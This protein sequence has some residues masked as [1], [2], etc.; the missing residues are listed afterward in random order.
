MKAYAVALKAIDDLGFEGFACTFQ[1]GMVSDHWQWYAWNFLFE[2]ELNGIPTTPVFHTGDS[3]GREL[4]RI[5]VD[6]AGIVSLQHR[7]MRLT[8]VLTEDAELLPFD[9]IRDVFETMITVVDKQTEAPAWNKPGMPKLEK[10]YFIQ[11][12]RLGLKPV[13]QYDN[14]G[15]VI[16]YFLIPAWDFLGYSTAKV[17]GMEEKTHIIVPPESFLTINAVD[18]TIIEYY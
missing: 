6:D 15:D 5:V 2:R 11:E 7:R 16:R 1:A 3:D 14:R 18:G 13:F 10:E 8:E 17:N 9:E 12:I 4:L